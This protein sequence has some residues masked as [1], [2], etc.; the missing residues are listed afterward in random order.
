MDHDFIERN[1]ASCTWAAHLTNAEGVVNETVG[2][3]SDVL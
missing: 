1:S 3:Y 2:K